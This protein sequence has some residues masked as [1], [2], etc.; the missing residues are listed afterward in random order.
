MHIGLFT[1]SYL[2]RQS[3]VVRAVEVTVRSLRR[4]GH[5]VSVIAPRYPRFTDT[6]PGVY[7]FPSISPPRYPDFP[8]AVP[9]STAHLHAI[10]ELQLDLVHTHSPF[11][12]GGVGLWAARVL[13]R[14]VIFT[15]HTLY[16]EYAHY[17]PVLGEVTRPLIVAFTT[18]YCNRC[19]RVLAS[20]PSLAVLLRQHG[21][22]VPIDVVPSAGVEPSEFDGVPAGRMRKH[23][24]IPEEAAL[25]IFVG[26]LGKE[27]G[28]PLLLAA[29]TAL[30]PSVWLLIVGDGPERASLGTCA[31]RLGV[32]SRVVF[33]GAQ[34]HA[35]VVEALATSDLF[36][37]P[38]RT[39]TLGLA[40]L[41]AMAAGR[42]VVAVAA[43]AT[44]DL[45]RDGENGRVVPP[46]PRAFAE[47]VRDLLGN[48]ERRAAMAARAR[49]VAGTFAQE[50]VTD[51]LIAAYEAAIAEH[52]ALA[53]RN[54]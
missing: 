10:Q 45:V 9:F 44:V 5:R 54:D 21:V 27:K 20:V 16:T 24:G 29:L 28:I 14:P 35:R 17:A 38:S 23:F 34:E 18:A 36:V 31:E 7:R 1:D 12:L 40:L 49:V 53:S 13:H 32:A 22:R 50:Q 41:E 39:E 37:F 46:D 52:G 43:G 48:A 25:L 6:D 26:R 4:R 2:P 19:D 11:L 8:L 42:A 51:R 30:P 47:A 33:A 3:G 15:Y